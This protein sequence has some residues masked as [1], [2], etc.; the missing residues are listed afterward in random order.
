M[1]YFTFRSC[2]IQEWCY[3]YSN[4]VHQCLQGFQEAVRHDVVTSQVVKFLRHLTSHDVELYAGQHLPHQRHDAGHEVL[5]RI[6]IGVVLE[7]PT[8]MMPDLASNGTFEERI[9]LENGRCTTRSTQIFAASP[10]LYS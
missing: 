8:K 10:T 6:H 4:S 3:I 7:A 5:H 9:S 1:Q 2:T